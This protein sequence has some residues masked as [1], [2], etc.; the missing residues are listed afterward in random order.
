MADD[1]LNQT[2]D[3]RPLAEEMVTLKEGEPASRNNHFLKP[4]PKGKD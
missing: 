2:E 4:I 3:K 1:E